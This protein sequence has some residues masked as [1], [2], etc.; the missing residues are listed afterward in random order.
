M[1][2]KKTSLASKELGE[3]ALAVVRV[4]LN[5]FLEVAELA[6]SPQA[7]RR[8]QPRLVTSAFAWAELARLPRPFRGAAVER[9][10]QVR[11]ELVDPDELVPE[12]AVC[13]SCV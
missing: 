4:N 6:G 11:E 5:G 3:L 1:I 2:G 10:G 12:K 7:C 9:V 8:L 13:P